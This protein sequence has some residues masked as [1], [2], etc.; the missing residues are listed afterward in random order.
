MRLEITRYS[1]RI[2]P[3]DNTVINQD[4]RDTA[5][6]EEVLGLKQNGDSITLM[7]R[8]VHGVSAIA[9]LETCRNEETK[10]E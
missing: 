8:N 6:I 10:N 2:V 3:E 1:L 9:C 4:E 7:R 5:Y